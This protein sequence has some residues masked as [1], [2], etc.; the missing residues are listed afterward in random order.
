[1]TNPVI[2][3]LQSTASQTKSRIEKTIRS[4]HRSSRSSGFRFAVAERI[5][6]LNPEPWDTL[7][8]SS[9]IF[10][11]RKYLEVLE[12][13]APDNLHPYYAILYLDNKPAAALV[14]QSV[15]ISAALIPKPFRTQTTA[16]Q[17]AER[18]LRRI[19]E[20]VLVCGNL[21]S[22]GAFH[23]VAFKPG[24]DPAKLWTG[25]EEVLYRI[26]CAGDPSTKPGL[27][28][29][30]DLPEDYPLDA[31]GR[32]NYR[33]FNAGSNMVL[34][35]DPTWQ[36]FDDYLQ[37]LRSNYRAPALKVRRDCEKA[38]ISVESLDATGVARHAGEIFKLYH[39]VH[40]AQML[41]L[42]AIQKSY[43]PALA[44]AFG[45]D[46]RTQ[47]AWNRERRM[48]GFVTC[49]KDRNDAIGYYI[50]FDKATAAQ[51]PIYLRL[52]QGVTE[53]GIRMRASQIN[54]GR[55][56]LQP[57]AQLG[58]RPQEFRCMVRHKIGAVNLV[59]KS[60]LHVLPEPEHPP[61]RNP[62]K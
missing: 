59:L 26:Q 32:L 51:A 48:V 28:L 18:S 5:S 7:T 1:M 25:V 55:T 62:F 10:L 44:E 14:A 35:L 43:V 22:W 49:M 3:R 50:G 46:F 52:L 17:A 2:G 24:V 8:Q 53:D 31:L 16:S 4:Y 27:T 9:S 61:V 58:A 57:K 45:T 42:V 11:G 56:A 34:L 39:Q 13:N 47:V 54:L 19:K 36:C 40:D 23:G 21:L 33:P 37:A 38:G 41:R 15:D 30:K 6:M 20:R 29:I 60:L 12:K